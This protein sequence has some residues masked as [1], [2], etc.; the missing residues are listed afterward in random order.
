MS[1]KQFLAIMAA[2][3]KV[4]LA[5]LVL[6]SG[7]VLL[8][9]LLI[10]KTYSAT[11]SIVIDVKPDPLGGLLSANGL[12]PALVETQL[13]IIQSDRVAAKV[14]RNLK[15][16]DNPTARQQWAD[17]T[18]G[19][20]DF[21]LWLAETLQR[22]LEARPSRASGVITIT[23]RSPDPKFAAVLANAF[24][25][26]Y[27]QTAVELRV[28]PA[29]QYASFF[30]SRMK[31]ARENLEK[32]QAKSST[33]QRENNVISID[34]RFDVETARLNELSA[35]L[36]VMQAQATEAA[37]RQGQAQGGSA[38]RMPE[39]LANPVVAGLKTDL[40]RGEVRLKE[41]S[42]RYG[43][44]HPLIGEAKANIAELKGRIEAETTRVVGSVGVTSTI[45]RKREGELRGA[46]EAQRA[47]VLKLKQIRDEGI[48]LAR[49]V[50][51]AQR[52]FEQ[53]TAR[54]NQSTIESQTTQ[55][56]VSLLS[57]ARSPNA[58]S[59][60]RVLLNTALGTILGLALAVAV[61]L[62]VEGVD[63]RLRLPSDIV[64]A[65]GLPIIGDIPGPGRRRAMGAAAVTMQQRL[66]A[67]SAAKSPGG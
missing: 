3:W 53:V 17:A 15:L 59:S 46:L 10:T 52:L 45:S 16:G 25:A 57:E 44:S 48:M 24:A 39:V 41:L 12:T 11:A 20:G 49:E 42:A 2:R 40:A 22:N 51:N 58:A 21:E 5:V 13:D 8:G 4:A 37:I 34:E 18:K 6:V 56:N 64:D 1:F 31:E 67:T 30:D 62:G 33:Y 23:Y 27:L 9:S 60:P 55:S 61:A 26:A 19:Q 50:D 43:D 54:S 47:K 14:V 28:D 7:G 32:A 66:L 65:L 35:Q 63:R 29:R 38:E 36:V